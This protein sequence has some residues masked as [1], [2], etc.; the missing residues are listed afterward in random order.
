M[1]TDQI[2]YL[3]MG[4]MLLSA[5]LAFRFPFELFLLAYAVLGPL[6]YLTEI[7]WLHDRQ[8]YT[9]GRQDYLFL[10][11]AS[12]II[13]ALNFN[14][15]PGLPPGTGP[16]VTCTAFFAALGFVLFQN[17]TARLAGM[18]CAFLL[19]LVLSP[20]PFFGPVFN[21]FLP[22]LIHVF[23]FTGFFILVGSLRGRN[24]SGF[25]SLAVF[26]A[27]ALAFLFIHPAHFSY[28]VSD[29]V[30]ESYGYFREDG[31]AS[32]VFIALNHY[33]V[34]ALG[35]NGWGATTQPLSEFVASVNNYLYQSPA[36]LALMSFI[37]FA[38]TYHYLN[39][40]SKTSII[41]WHE[42]PQARFIMVLFLWAASLALYAANYALGFKWLF[43][44][45]FAHVLLE[46][47]L[48]H[49]TFINIA[50]E[51]KRIFLPRGTQ[52]RI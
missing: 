36:A 37:A 38:Y 34:K 11:L 51:G 16:A 20:F 31:T 45:S 33:L 2:N 18:A 28:R 23:L 35:L 19:S 10:G 3:N 8:Y 40:F 43:F 21:L 46:F 17:L 32:S 26:A 24:L 9:K 41:R 30:R 25:L 13:T 42:V 50:K 48:N 39:W 12:V 7:S 4:L 22:T 15:V 29:Y 44:L 49:L 14:W 6:H 47:P 1:T 5:L 27:V 52:G